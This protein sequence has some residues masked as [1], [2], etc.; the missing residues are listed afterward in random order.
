MT[1]ILRNSKGS[2]LTIADMDGNLTYL[3]GKTSADTG[4][5]YLTDVSGTDFGIK[6]QNAID[7]LSSSGGTINTRGIAGIQTMSTPI[8]INK[9]VIIYLGEMELI[10]NNSTGDNNMFNILSDNVSIVGLGKSSSGDNDYLTRLTMSN[11]AGQTLQGYHVYSKGYSLIKINNLDIIGVSTTDGH[12]YG[13]STYP[14]DGVGGVYIEKANPGTVSAGNAVNGVQ[15][16]NVYIERTKAHGIYIDTPI[17]SQI[18]NVRVSQAGG[19]GIFIQNGTSIL[20]MNIYI[21]S[22]NYGGIVLKALSYSS[23]IN[24]ASEYAGV[25]YWFRSITNVSGMALGNE[26][27]NNMG[28]APWSGSNPETAAYGLNLNTYASDGTTPVEISDVNSTAATLFRGT[29]YLITGGKNLTLFNP[30][31]TNPGRPKNTNVYPSGTGLSP[32]SRFI[33]VLTTNSNTIIYN[34]ITTY[35]TGYSGITNF[36]IEIDTDVENLD[37]AFDPELN[38]TVTPSIPGKY[39]TNISSDYAPIFNDSTTTS[40]HAVIKFLLVIIIV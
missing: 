8:N 33:Q 13:S 21:S 9:P 31:G 1:L 37:L 15:I 35:S 14:L 4:E 28:A 18:S 2:K 20:L 39:I 19:H 12:Q 6:L 38:G 16:D 30:Y 24:C 26:M 36:D 11:S 10:M 27:L 23:L 22:A 34:P 5:I 40:I 29:G 7:S 32:D 3:S 17:L 25:G